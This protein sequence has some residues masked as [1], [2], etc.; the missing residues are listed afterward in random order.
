MARPSL[1]F[2]AVTFGYDGSD[3]LIDSLS[4][5][6]D[7]GWTA[8]VGANGAGKTT[9]LGLASG[10]LAPVRGIVRVP[11]RV[12]LCEQRTDRPSD[13]VVALAASG[14]GA[15]ARWRGMLAV[16]AGAV[17]RWPL[18]SHGERKRLQVAAAL[19][20]EPDLLALDEPTNHLDA[21]TAAL[22]REALAA[23]RGI[24]LLVSHDRALLDAVCT[25]T[26]VARGGRWRHVALRPSDARTTVEAGLRD[27][28]RARELASAEV[29]R[30]AALVRQRE[31]VASRS[32]RRLSKRHLAR[33]DRD[34]KGRIDAARLT[35]KDARAGRLL[36]Q[37]RQRAS[38]AREHVESF[39]VQREFRV[40]ITMPGQRSERRVLA[41]LGPISLALG[42]RRTLEVPRFVLG[43]ADRVHVTGPNGSG[44][45]TFV[46]SLVEA[47]RASGRAL[48]YIPQE[49]TAAEGRALLDEV[50]SR[51]PEAKGR[52]MTIVRRLGSD[53][54]RLLASETPSPGEVRKLAI[55]VGL[56]EGVEA[57][58]LDEP[59]NHLD[60][61]S[62]EALEQALSEA[63]R[64][65][66]IV[67]HDL[68]F[69][70]RLARS[71][72]AIERGALARVE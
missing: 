62:I 28:R 66:V 65:L 29:V 32:S 51:S 24:G 64:A 52:V 68:A 21:E 69:S 33:G 39:A 9:L 45:S 50:C 63:A 48:I 70:R 13:A 60:L 4:L 55:A 59:T 35:G 54:H 43:A 22:V 15:A 27:V 36:Q 10:Q 18:L 12:Q 67:S 38:Q 47:L 40:G 2:D 56:D 26:I 3:L 5:H 41:D 6:L 17:G 34:A 7:A 61:P 53:P 58:V 25:G 20:C 72:W 31:A 42:P 16:E 37:A 11:P 44:K 46:R 57:I 71:T 1:V 8:I 30:L 49:F 23:Y 14:D 19:W